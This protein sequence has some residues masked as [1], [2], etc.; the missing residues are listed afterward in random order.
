SRIADLCGN[1][2]EFERRG[3]S[4]V[5]IN[6]SAGRQI[7]I[8]IGGDRNVEIALYVAESNTRHVFV[9]YEHDKAGDLVAVVD[10]LDNPYT[11]AY[12]AHRMVRHTD[13]NG[14]SFYYEYDK[15]S[16]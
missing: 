2:L 1:W 12:D 13:R 8:A 6:E 14:L 16:V 11:F 15:N 3:D 7:E 4:L 9:R 10:A 5:A